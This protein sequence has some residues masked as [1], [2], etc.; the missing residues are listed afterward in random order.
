MRNSSQ[1]GSICPT[2][3]LAVRE[4]LPL[5]ALSATSVFQSRPL[6]RS[7][8]CVEAAVSAAAHGSRLRGCCCCC[9]FL[10]IISAE[11]RAAAA[12]PLKHP[13]PG[14]EQCG[15]QAEVCVHISCDC[16][17]DSWCVVGYHE[18]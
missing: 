9:C 2:F 10:C 12:C 16:C 4:L 14:A 13:D 7:F 8:R 15:E 11:A 5:G 1:K 6:L 18:V 17:I 3:P